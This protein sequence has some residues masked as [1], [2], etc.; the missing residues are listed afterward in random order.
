MAASFKVKFF[1]ADA[2]TLEETFPAS[3]TVADAKTKLI[4]AWPAGVVHSI[5]V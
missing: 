2:Q 4:A 3:T 1:F 5:P